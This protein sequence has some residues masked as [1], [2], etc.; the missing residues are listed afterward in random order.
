M[1]LSKVLNIIESE[2]GDFEDFDMENNGLMFGNKKNEIKRVYFCW[3]ITTDI[4]NKIK[5]DSNTLIICH[6]PIT[7]KINN[8][9]TNDKR[10][11]I[12]DKISNILKKS[13]V[14]VARYHLPLDNSPYG[15]NDTILS[16]IGGK[17]IEKKKYFGINILSKPVKTNELI[18][19]LKQKLRFPFAII[20]GNPNKKIRKILIIAGGGAT[21]EMVNYAINKG[22]DAIISGDSKMQSRFLAYEGKIILIDIPHQYTEMPGI[23]RFSQKIKEKFENVHVK[24]IKNEIKESCV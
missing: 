8:V 23:K 7:Y 6:E 20:I 1:K 16:I 4:L 2:L 18:K 24:F 9:L 12:N 13:K 22:C 5:L 11:K 3:K 17:N 15:I 10:C 14:N 21:K 19:T